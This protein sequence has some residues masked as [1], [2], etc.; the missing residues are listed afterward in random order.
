MPLGDGTTE[1]RDL[2]WRMDEGDNS[3]CKVGV[4]GGSEAERWLAGLAVLSCEHQ[5]AWGGGQLGGNA[6]VVKLGAMC[7][8]GRVGGAN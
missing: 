6:A 7:L 4:P 1:G 2:L 3:K 5:R 8:C